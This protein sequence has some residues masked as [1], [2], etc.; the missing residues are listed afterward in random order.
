M[1]LELTHELT[2]TRSSQAEQLQQRSVDSTEAVTWSPTG[3][4]DQ[5]KASRDASRLRT[6]PDQSG[7]VGM[8][9]IRKQETQVPLPIGVGTP[10]KV[11]E[12][13]QT[14]FDLSLE[15]RYNPFAI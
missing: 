11:G 4:A 15:N 9:S 7:V 2:Q 12:R 10:P 3:E 13:G 1:A 8:P 6:H 14:N 5:Q